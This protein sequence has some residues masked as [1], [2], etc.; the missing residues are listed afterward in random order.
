M[1]C[2]V[3]CIQEM[4]ASLSEGSSSQEKSSQSL[5]DS[6]TD[7]PDLIGPPAAQPTEFLAGLHGTTHVVQAL[8]PSAAQPGLITQEPAGPSVQLGGGSLPGGEA[9]TASRGFNEMLGDLTMPL[10]IEL[11]NRAGHSD[12][13]RSRWERGSQSIIFL[14]FS[15]K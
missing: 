14:I 13:Q 4:L 5:L 6:T 11:D 2:I 12:T 9:L 1:H 3:S 10:R 15:W 7:E 8:A